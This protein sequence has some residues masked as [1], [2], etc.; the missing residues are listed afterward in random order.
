MIMKTIG[1]RGTLFSDTPIYVNVYRSVYQ[2][3]PHHMTAC[4]GEY[5]SSFDDVTAASLSH[6]I[7]SIGGVWWTLWRLVWE[8]KY[9][10]HIHCWVWKWLY[11]LQWM[12]LSNH[13]MGWLPTILTISMFITCHIKWDDYHLNGYINGI[14]GMIFSTIK[15]GNLASTVFM[16]VMD[17]LFTL[18]LWLI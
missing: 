5:F 18:W 14:I 8:A 16:D 15:F 3:K 11:N 4:C 17:Q 9:T 1:F 10:I 13:Q 6:S 12:I 7:P 2:I